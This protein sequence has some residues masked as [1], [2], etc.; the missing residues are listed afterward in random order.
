MIMNRPS[1]HP[2]CPLCGH[3]GR[4]Q[5]T[6]PE[7][8]RFPPASLVRLRVFKCQSCGTIYSER[9]TT[10]EVAEASEVAAS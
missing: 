5:I 6:S 3:S 7:P 2:P 10:E 4:E 9:Q 8:A 1:D